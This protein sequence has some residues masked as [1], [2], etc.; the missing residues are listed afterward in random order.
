MA[1][2]DDA[3]LK[4]AEPTTIKLYVYDARSD[5]CSTFLALELELEGLLFFPFPF[6]SFSFSLFFFPAAAVRCG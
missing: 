2:S 6:L 1:L 5:M 4:S 3:R